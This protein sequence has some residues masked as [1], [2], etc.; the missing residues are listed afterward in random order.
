MEFFFLLTLSSV[1]D[2]HNIHV[3]A[4][5]FVAVRCVLMLID[6]ICCML[7]QPTNEDASR[8]INPSFSVCIN[9][10]YLHS[11]PFIYD[12]QIYIYIY[13]YSNISLFVVIIYIYVY[14]WS[15]VCCLDVTYPL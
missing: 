5:G 12:N 9:M 6:V 10:V 2:G 13:V 7:A 4:V 8:I 3:F 15:A 1:R 11:M 14:K